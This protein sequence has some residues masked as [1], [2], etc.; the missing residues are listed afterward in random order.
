MLS[1]PDRI[2]KPCRIFAGITHA[3]YD[4][5]FDLEREASKK[6]QELE[7]KVERRELI[8]VRDV[9]THQKVRRNRRAVAIEKGAD[10]ATIS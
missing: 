8:T 3:G 6:H 9:M 5:S 7:A 1:T 4:C 10:R 2:S